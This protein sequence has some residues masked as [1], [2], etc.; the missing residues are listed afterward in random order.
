MLGRVE[1]GRCE[2]T[3]ALFAFMA[4]PLSESSGGSG[5]R[6]PLVPGALCSADAYPLMCLLLAV[7]AGGEGC[8]VFTAPARCEYDFFAMD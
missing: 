5:E 1:G 4:T 7:A 6:C 3:L 8:G 2:G